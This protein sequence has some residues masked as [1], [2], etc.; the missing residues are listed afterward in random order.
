MPPV[1]GRNDRARGPG[2]TL[3]R[4]KFTGKTADWQKVRIGEPADVQDR[5][6]PEPFDTGM[7]MIEIVMSMMIMMVAMSILTAGFLQIYRATAKIDSLSNAQGQTA[8]AFRR[9][10]KEIRYSSS[11]SK[12]GV[13][14]TDYYVEYV[15]SV[16]DTTTPPPTAPPLPTTTCVELR[17]NA[18]SGQLQRRSWPKGRTPLT[19]TAWLPLIASVVP[20]QP[21]ALVAADPVHNYVRLNMSLT[22]SAGTGPNQTRRSTNVTFVALNSPFAE[23]E[24][25]VCAEGRAIP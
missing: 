5:A 21:F 7:T 10:D 16:S 18:S 20:A 13:I 17:L 12:P 19:P 22:V 6:T 1:R 15:L 24:D 9:L 3:R 25:T 23:P 11:I 4:S 14:G 8:I 2:A